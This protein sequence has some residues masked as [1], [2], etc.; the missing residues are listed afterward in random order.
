MDFT[1]RERTPRQAV[2]LGIR[3]RD[4]AAIPPQS[5]AL[6]ELGVERS[7][8]AVHDRVSD[9]SRTEVFVM[10]ASNSSAR[11]TQNRPT[12]RR[13]CP[14][15]ITIDE[16][17]VHDERFWMYA[18]VSPRNKHLLYI[19]LFHS[20]TTVAT[21]IFLRELNQKHDVG[22]GLFILDGANTFRPFSVVPVF[23]SGTKRG[24]RLR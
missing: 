6:E 11:E 12:S 9:P 15:S 1:K 5:S 16:T 4:R 3:A 18:D 2:R 20:T 7:N 24:S 21:E 23:D 13:R 10:S 19:R 14:E 17:V 8:K 22:D